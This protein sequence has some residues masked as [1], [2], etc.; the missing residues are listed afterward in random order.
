[1]RKIIQWNQFRRDYKRAKRRGQN[2]EKLEVVVEQL[3]QFGILDTVH[4]PHKL[5]GKWTGFWECHIAPDWL[6]IYAINDDEVLLVRM[7]SHS[8]LFS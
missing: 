4:R 5:T 7:G 1:M 8:D 3:V 6:L 2:V